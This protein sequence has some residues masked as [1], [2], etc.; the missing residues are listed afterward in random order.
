MAQVYGVVDSDQPE[1]IIARLQPIADIAPLYDQRIAITTYANVMA[2]AP[3]EA[4]HDTQGEPAARSALM[5]H[6]TPEFAADA[7]RASCAAEPRTS[8]RFAQLAEQ[9][10][11]RRP[12]PRR[13]RGARPTS[14]WWRSVL[15]ASAS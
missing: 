3:E 12:T 14:R 5:E 8:S 2:N 1:T 13:T 11:I 10:P 9:F 4:V 6:I 15:T 7:A